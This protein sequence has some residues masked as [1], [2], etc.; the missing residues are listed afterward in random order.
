L[1]ALDGRM[2]SLIDL[3]DVLPKAM[4]EPSTAKPA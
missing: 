1:I 3:E 4:L 2:I